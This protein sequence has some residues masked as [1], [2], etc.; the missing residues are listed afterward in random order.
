MDFTWGGFSEFGRGRRSCSHHSGTFCFF[1]IQETIYS[2]TLELEIELGSFINIVQGRKWL[3]SSETQIT[4]TASEQGDLREY[5]VPASQ[6]C[7]QEPTA[8]R[9]PALD[10]LNQPTL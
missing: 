9:A 10:I 7:V 5:L 4:E 8:S 2:I 3:M 1:G 6:E